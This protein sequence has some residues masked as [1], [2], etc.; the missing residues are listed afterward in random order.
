MIEEGHYA[1]GQSGDYLAMSAES[2]YVANQVSNAVDHVNPATNEL[3]DSYQLLA[4]PTLLRYS[5]STNS[6]YVA[7]ESVA[8][9]IKINLDTGLQPTIETTGEIKSMELRDNLLYFTTESLGS[10]EWDLSS[11][12]ENDLTTDHGILDADLIMPHPITNEIV[13]VKTGSSPATVYRYTFD[14][15]DQIIELQ[16]TR[17]LGSNARDIAI[18]NN[19]QSLAVVAGGGN[20]DGYTIHNVDPSDLT[21]SNG[22]GTPTPT[23]YLQIFLPMVV[24][25]QRATRQIS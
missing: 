23:L 13:A 12:D 20:G 2:L 3:I 6:L 25:S 15:N 9:I 11:V 4:R 21:V 1:T 18:I 7:L 16:S 5:D 17:D 10:Y 19:G 24:Y 14:A 22:L 8:Q